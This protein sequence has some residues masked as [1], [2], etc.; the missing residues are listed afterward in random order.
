MSAR[1]GERA[2]MSVRECEGVTDRK[3]AQ[4]WWVSARGCVFVGFVGVFVC[5]FAVSL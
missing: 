2:Y 5:C 3:S 1:D 4:A